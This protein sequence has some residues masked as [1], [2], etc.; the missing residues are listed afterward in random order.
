MTSVVWALLGISALF[1]AYILAIN[2]QPT[3]NYIAFTIG[4][5]DLC[6]QPKTPTS[7][8]YSLNIS[9]CTFQSRDFIDIFCNAVKVKVSLCLALNIYSIILGLRYAMFIILDM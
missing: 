6:P 4:L 3:L 8:L 1:N 9:S 5:R 7:Y 2:N